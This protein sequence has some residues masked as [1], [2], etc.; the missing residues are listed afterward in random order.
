MWT[1]CCPS[2]KT[3]H[4]TRRPCLTIRGIRDQ[5]ATHFGAILGLY[6]DA[7]VLEVTSGGGPEPEM[8]GEYFRSLPPAQFHKLLALGGAMLTGT[9]DDRF[10][11][12]LDLLMRA[13]P[14]RHRHRDGAV[15]PRAEYSVISH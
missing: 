15:K 12:G 7:S 10:E 4:T 11:F 2:T 1:I 8:V 6:L 5:A 13:S 9:R 3:F 14:P